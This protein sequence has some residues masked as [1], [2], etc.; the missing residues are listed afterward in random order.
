MSTVFVAPHARKS[1]MCKALSGSMKLQHDF[2]WRVQ[3]TDVP[4]QEIISQ[5]PRNGVE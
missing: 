3:R 2:A 1:A 4:E 5:R